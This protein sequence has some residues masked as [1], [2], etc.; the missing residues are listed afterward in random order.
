MR[1]LSLDA[2]KEHQN[3]DEYDGSA[4]YGGPGRHFMESEPDPD[5]AMGVSTAPMS[6]VSR[7]GR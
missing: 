6:A 5:R 2:N 3:R 1:G 4:G 7:A